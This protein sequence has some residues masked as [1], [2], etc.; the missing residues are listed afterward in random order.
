MKRRALI[1]SFLWLCHLFAVPTESHNVLFFTRMNIS[2]K[3]HTCSSLRS[4]ASYGIDLTLIGMENHRVELRKSPTMLLKHLA[5]L[6]HVDGDDIIVF[7]DGPS[8]LYAAN[9]KQIEN[10]FVKIETGNSVFFAAEK[11]CFPGPSCTEKSMNSS[12]SH[13]YVHSSS[14]I[15]RRKEVIKLLKAWARSFNSLPKG[16]RDEQLALQRLLLPKFAPDGIE[17]EIDHGCRIFQ[18]LSSSQLDSNKWAVANPDGPYI[19]PNGLFYNAE[20]GTEP[21]IYRFSSHFSNISEIENLMWKSHNLVASFA[22]RFMPFCDAQLKKYPFVRVCMTEPSVMLNCDIMGQQHRIR[23][24]SLGVDRNW[25]PE[26]IPIFSVRTDITTN[27]SVS[28]LRMHLLHGNHRYPLIEYKRI[29]QCPLHQPDLYAQGGALSLMKF[30]PLTA[31]TLMLTAAYIDTECKL[32]NGCGKEVLKSLTGYYPP[33]FNTT[34]FT[35]QYSLSK[36]FRIINGTFYYDWPWG[37]ER[38]DGLFDKRSINYKGPIADVLRSVSNLPDS[39][40]FAGGEGAVLPAN[41]PVPHMSS[42]PTGTSSSDVPGLWNSPFQ[43]EKE[44]SKKGHNE[45]V[46]VMH[47]KRLLQELHKANINSTSGDRFPSSWELRSDKAAFFGSIGTDLGI[48]DY[49]AARQVVYDIAADFPEHVDA[50]HTECNTHIVGLDFFFYCP[51]FSSDLEN[52]VPISTGLSYLD[53]STPVLLSSPLMSCPLLFFLSCTLLSCPLTSCPVLSCPVLFCPVLSY[54]VLSCP[55]MSCPLMSCPLLSCPLLSCP[56]LS[57]P[58]LSCPVLS[59]PVLSSL[60]MSCPLLSCPLISCPVMS[61]PLMSCPLM[62]CPLMSSP[63]LSCPLMSCPLMS[64]PLLSCPLMSCPVLSCHVLSCPVLSC[65]VLSSHVLSSHV[66]SCPLMSSHALSCPL[67][68][69]TLLTY[70]ILLCSDLY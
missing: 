59:C 57:C 70:P 56:V 49:A 40:F 42:S 25:Y 4:A 51:I 38:L 61:C 13:K 32:W 33:H 69:C 55:V 14:F 67:M 43:Y 54:P 23:S 35:G 11:M 45:S 53:F 52:T 64:S 22:S 18:T 36:L 24:A 17:I 21:L 68:S 66:L 62:S 8:V 10:A 26:S 9:K 58:V 34:I 27:E 19:R 63:L 65:P 30:I 1:S 44:R 15:G 7:N 50:G 12:S 60:V 2:D 16:S 6:S 3:S 46:A 5:N 37:I 47:E 29:L 20:T 39:V 31:E 28:R 41:V 48:G